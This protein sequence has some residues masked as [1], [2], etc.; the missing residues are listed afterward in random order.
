M[1]RGNGEG[2]IVKRKDGR[3]MGAV[4]IGTDPETGKP[5]RKYIYGKKRK[6]V[7]RK[8]TELKQKLFD[9]SYIKQSEIKL[10]EWLTRWN[11][12]RK[13]QLA[14]NTYRAYKVWINK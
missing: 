1:A 3:W 9:G 8:M 10:G 2:T 6:E 5:D 4:T 13:S 11:E 7:A 14:Y 12:G